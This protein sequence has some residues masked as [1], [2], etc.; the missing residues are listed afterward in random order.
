MPDLIP[1]PCPADRGP[2]SVR[3]FCAESAKVAEGL[4]A[5]FTLMAFDCA[6]S[7]VRFADATT[8]EIGPC[9][10]D[11]A[12]REFEVAITKYGCRNVKGAEKI[13]NAFFEQIN[14]RTA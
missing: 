9:R 1:L 3:P 8:R 5:S 4:A 12:L 11:P 13:K 2:L 7:C 14:R 6:D 10:Y